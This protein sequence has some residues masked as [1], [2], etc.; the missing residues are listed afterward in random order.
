MTDT[1]A[2]SAPLGARYLFLVAGVPLTAV[3]VSIMDTLLPDI[4]RQ[5][6]I[7]VADASLVDAI[8]V[9]VAGALMV[10]AENSQT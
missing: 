2:L 8:T 4:V 9:T 3:D 10:P 7:S 5:L 6:N 1:P